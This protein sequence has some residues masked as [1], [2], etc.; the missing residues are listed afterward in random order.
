MDK[1]FNFYYDKKL[2][3]IPIELTFNPNYA[4]KILINILIEDE[5]LSN[6]MI[7]VLKWNLNLS[8]ILEKNRDLNMLLIAS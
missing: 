2:Y 4:K 1:G 6:E 5:V 7:E 3:F 8:N